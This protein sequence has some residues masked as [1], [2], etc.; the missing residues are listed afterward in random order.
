[1]RIILLHSCQSS[2]LLW[3]VPHHLA[4]IVRG[5][6]FKASN[7][8]HSD[9]SLSNLLRNSSTSLNPSYIGRSLTSIDMQRSDLIIMLQFSVVTLCNGSDIVLFPCLNLMCKSFRTPMGFVHLRSDS[10]SLSLAWLFCRCSR[11]HHHCRSCAPTLCST[12][13]LQ[14]LTVQTRAENFSQKSS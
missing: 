7:H 13:L 10:P 11:S 8:C 14:C 3:C 5:T 4:S 12:I 2:K 1:M 6:H 9:T